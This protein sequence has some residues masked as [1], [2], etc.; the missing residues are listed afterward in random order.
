LT[1]DE[2]LK[3]IEVCNK[4]ESIFNPTPPTPVVHFTPP[5]QSLQKDNFKTAKNNLNKYDGSRD[6]SKLLEFILPAERLLKLG[7]NLN[8]WGQSGTEEVQDLSTYLK[9]TAHNWYRQN[10]EL[11]DKGTPTQPADGD[12]FLQKLKKEFMPTNQ[13]EISRAELRRLKQTKEGCAVYLKKFRDIR[14]N[15]LDMDEE[16]TIRRFIDGLNPLLKLELEKTPEFRRRHKIPMTLTEIFEEA[17]SL[18]AV[19]FPKSVTKSERAAKADTTENTEP[20]PMDIDSVQCF[21]CKQPGHIK[22]NCPTVKKTP[23]KCIYHPLS[24]T[25]NTDQCRN[26]GVKKV[27]A[28]KVAVTEPLIKEV[29]E[30]Y[31]FSP[32]EV[33]I[34]KIEF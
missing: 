26:K 20:D 19:L 2:Q 27:T 23:K 21:A 13:S 1:I 30:N 34:N 18:D 11:L 33:S 25:H 4:L 16:E 12:I 5:A 10:K 29:V 15:I 8:A 28:V 6:V 17:E 14:V 9:D 3:V 22:R 24:T 31:E 32:H 7:R